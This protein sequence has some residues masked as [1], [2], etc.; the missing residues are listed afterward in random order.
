MPPKAG[1]RGYELTSTDSCQ[2]VSA[3]S[4]IAAASVPELDM[5]RGVGAM[6]CF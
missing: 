1:E 2:I 4:P 6:L 3:G 5:L